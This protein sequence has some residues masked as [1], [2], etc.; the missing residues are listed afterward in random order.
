[1]T[2]DTTGQGDGTVGIVRTGQLAQD[3]DTRHS[4]DRTGTLDCGHG[5]D[6]TGTL[7]SGHGT[8]RTGTLKSGHDTDKTGTLKIGH[9][10]DRTG[11]L[12]SGHGTDRTGLLESGHSTDRDIGH[13]KTRHGTS[14]DTT[15]DTKGV[16][17]RTGSRDT[18]Q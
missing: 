18:E 17:D 10:T 7:K 8:D 4:T 11:T 13:Q 15:Q 3:R 1:M 6:R 14:E 12:K 16:L 9:G 5:T 2:L